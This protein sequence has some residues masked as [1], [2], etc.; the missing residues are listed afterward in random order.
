MLKRGVSDSSKLQIQKQIT[1]HLPTSAYFSQVFPIVQSYKFKSKSQPYIWR[2][3]LELGVSDSS[4]LQIQK[5]ITTVG[6]LSATA[7]TGVSDSSKLQIQ[8]QITTGVPVRHQRHQ[9]FPIVQSYKFKSKSQQMQAKESRR[10][11][12]F[13]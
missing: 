7:L 5:Q 4:K 12:C 1:T 10:R 8:K 9:V 6:T 2:R 11:W 3:E 13:R